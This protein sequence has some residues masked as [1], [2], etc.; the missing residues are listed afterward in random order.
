MKKRNPLIVILLMFLTFSIYLYIYAYKTTSELKQKTG[1]NLKPGLDI[2]LI[3]IGCSPWLLYIPYRNQKIIDN[4]YKAR[5]DDHK[6]KAGLI[7]LIAASP[8]IL[9]IGMGM[10]MGA[11]EIGEDSPALL[12]IYGVTLVIWCSGIFIYQ[13]EQNNFAEET[14][15]SVTLSIFE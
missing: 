12:A 9:F 15:A 14:E 11:L 4:W 6:P 8:I 5:S 1:A 13:T 3:L 2:I 10:L 7:G